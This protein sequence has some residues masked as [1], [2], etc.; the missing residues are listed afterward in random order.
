MNPCDIFEESGSFTIEPLDP[1]E[2]PPIEASDDIIVFGDIV[3]VMKPFRLDLSVSAAM[4]AMLKEAKEKHSPMIFTNDDETRGLL[5][6][7]VNDLNFKITVNGIP[8]EEI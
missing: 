7:D 1:A 8:F 3:D 6:K 4:I 5:I 2:C